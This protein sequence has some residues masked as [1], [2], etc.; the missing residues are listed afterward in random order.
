MN[1]INKIAIIGLT[2][3]LSLT[4]LCQNAY[5]Q[6]GKTFSGEDLNRMIGASPV[7]PQQKP[8][9]PG[10]REK[11][12]DDST[13]KQDIEFYN[14]AGHKSEKWNELIAPAFESFDSGN[15]A[16]ALVF[17]QKAYDRGCRDAL[18]LFRL[19]LYRETTGALVKAADL[20]KLAAEK[21]PG[22]YRSHPLAREVDGHAA[23]TL[24]RVD[25]TDDALLHIQKALKHKPDDFMLLFMGG[26][27][28]RQK[29]EN[30]QALILLKKAST[31]PIPPEMD[32]D[33]TKR[34]LLNELVAINYE[35]GDH[36]SSTVYINE[37]FKISPNDPTARHYMQLIAREK[38]RL[39]QNEILKNMVQ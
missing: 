20:I 1:I 14:K 3:S 15:L 7:I 5:A 9:A 6:P 18:L 17:M 37:V 2:A 36:Q 30:E 21:L 31:M 34:T 27:I 13:T 26:Q 8:A 24:Y 23:R 4:S 39:K 32:K 16:T 25:R 22:Q 10:K 29:K 38:N 12:A 33:F 11:P 28:L 35:L 19:A